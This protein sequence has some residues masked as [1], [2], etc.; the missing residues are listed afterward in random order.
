MRWMSKVFTSHQNCAGACE[1]FPEYE[2]FY[3]YCQWHDLPIDAAPLHHIV[4]QA[5]YY[6]WADAQISYNASPYFSFG[7]DEL[8]DRILPDLVLFHFRNPEKIVNSLF[9]RNW[10]HT[11]LS[12]D[13]STA[14]PGLQPEHLNNFYYNFVRP[15]P[16]GEAY[17]EWAQLTRI[18]QIAWYCSQVA[19]SIDRVLANRPEVPRWHIRLEDVDQNY[20]FYCQMAHAVGLSP[21]LSRRRFLSLKGNVGNAGTVTRGA[22]TWSAEERRDFETQIAPYQ[23]IYE[24]SQSPFA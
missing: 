23:E 6:D 15:T 24:R 8:C 12:W 3:R 4:Q 13:T 2:A 1:R 18:G 19:T 14:V 16:K 7:A 21:I 5:V 22:D 10:Y 9:V 11:P 17:E 20:E